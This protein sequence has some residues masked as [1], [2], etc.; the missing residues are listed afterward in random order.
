MQTQQGSDLVDQ[1]KA[2]C[3]CGKAGETYEVSLRLVALYP[4][5][6]PTRGWGDSVLYFT[7]LYFGQSLAW[8]VVHS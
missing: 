4:G 6:I 5:G 7:V 1:A 8:G 2:F 3:A